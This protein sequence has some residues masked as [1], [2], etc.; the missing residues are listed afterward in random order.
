MSGF[1]KKYYPYLDEKKAFWLE[2]FCHAEAWLGGA[3]KPRRARTNES[4]YT[5]LYQIW[6]SSHPHVKL[7]TK[8]GVL[9]HGSCSKI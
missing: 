5:V 1:L 9:A 7:I 6:F 2:G 3:E 4:W 8:K